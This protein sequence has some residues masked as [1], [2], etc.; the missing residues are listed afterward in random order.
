MTRE[1]LEDEIKDLNQRFWVE[2][3]MQNFDQV[4]LIQKRVARC[5]ALLRILEDDEDIKP[6]PKALPVADMLNF[7]KKLKKN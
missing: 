5:E 2:L 3:T 7:M 1:Q 6:E 4:D